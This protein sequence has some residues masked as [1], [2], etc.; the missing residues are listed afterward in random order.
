MALETGDKL[1]PYE[2]PGSL[3]AGGMG[4]MYPSAPSAISGNRMAFT[5]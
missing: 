1:G 3:G 5:C 4:E 2:I